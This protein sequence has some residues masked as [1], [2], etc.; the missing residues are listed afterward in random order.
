MNQRS[1]SSDLIERAP[2]SVHFRTLDAKTHELSPKLLEAEQPAVRV[3]DVDLELHD[4][5][6]ELRHASRTHS[7]ARAEHALGSAAE[8]AELKRG[9]LTPPYVGVSPSHS[10]WNC[11]HVSIG[12]ASSRSRV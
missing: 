11:A 5:S 2:A 9:G 12:V 4:S 6:V 1:L 10:P 3:P 7:L 8:P